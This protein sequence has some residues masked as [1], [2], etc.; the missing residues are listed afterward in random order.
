M[1]RVQSAGASQAGAST[2]SMSGGV[3]EVRWD[4]LRNHK[5]W[6]VIW[7]L[8]FWNPRHHRGINRGERANVVVSVSDRLFCR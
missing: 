4:D 8:A 1:S 7:P 5:V 3:V 6:T 2:A